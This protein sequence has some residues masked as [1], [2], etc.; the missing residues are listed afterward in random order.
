M[1]NELKRLLLQEDTDISIIKA[2]SDL[3]AS[4]DANDSFIEHSDTPS[5]FS[6]EA[7]NILAVNGTE[8]AIEFIST[9]YPAIDEDNMTSNS[10]VH[11]PTQQ[12]VKA[13]V[14][15]LIA[16]KIGALLEDTSPQ[17]GGDL[18]LNQNYIELSPTPTSDHT[19]NGIMTQLVYGESIALFEVLYMKSDGKLWR[20]DA[21]AEATSIGIYL[22]LEAGSADQTKKVLMLGFARDDSWTW[23]VGGQLFLD[24][25]TGAL[26]Q[27]RP[28]GTGDIIIVLGIAKSATI[29]DFR[30]TIAYVEHT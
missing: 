7:G 6:G 11:V 4:I 1:S 16:T 22:A 27:T 2:I 13:Y 3:Q 21:D 25:T 9:H 8:D 14:D 18:D 20:A 28:S 26:T 19:A 10:D 15:T 30:P 24:T 23:T 17:L 5:S 12:S 29:I